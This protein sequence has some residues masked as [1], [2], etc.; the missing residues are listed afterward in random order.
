M[1][2]KLTASQIEIVLTPV[3]CGNSPI[4]GYTFACVDFLKINRI[5]LTSESLDLFYSNAPFIWI[6]IGVVLL[7]LAII[8][9]SKV[10]QYLT[11]EE[12]KKAAQEET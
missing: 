8:S 1:R 4:P 10:Q 2:E 5:N 11:Y 12:E 3:A 6:V 7:T 9:N